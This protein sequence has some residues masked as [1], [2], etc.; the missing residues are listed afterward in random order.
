MALGFSGSN[1]GIQEA[2]RQFVLADVTAGIEKYES[3]YST[4]PEKEREVR[5]FYQQAIEG[6]KKLRERMGEGLERRL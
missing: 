1:G 4:I 3:L 6:L 5:A 2:Y